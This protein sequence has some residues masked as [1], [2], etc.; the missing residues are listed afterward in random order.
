MEAC[1]PG[2]WGK[3]EN[4]FHSLW[5][6]V[7]AFALALAAVVGACVSPWS[8]KVEVLPGKAHFLDHVLKPDLPKWHLAAFG[9]FH[10]NLETTSR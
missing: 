6:I 7:P 2:I 8:C 9:H 4:P 10:A 5:Y 3:R 1:D